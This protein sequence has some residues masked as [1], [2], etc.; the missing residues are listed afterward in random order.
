MSEVREQTSSLNSRGACVLNARGVL[1]LVAVFSSDQN[2]H[3]QLKYS[4]LANLD[5]RVLVL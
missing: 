1:Q 5:E 3:D 4:N 2:P